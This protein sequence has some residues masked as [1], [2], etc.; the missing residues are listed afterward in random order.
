M[1]WIAFYVLLIP[2]IGG[3]AWYV[4]QSVKLR[5]SRADA[6]RRIRQRLADKQREN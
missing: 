1:G 2:L 3:I 6:L 4:I 5:R